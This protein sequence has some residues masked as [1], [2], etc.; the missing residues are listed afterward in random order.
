MRESIQA[1]ISS[2]DAAL[3][4]RLS[5]PEWISA[6]ADQKAESLIESFPG[7]WGKADKR[8]L[9]NLLADGRCY[10][11]ACFIVSRL[12]GVRARDLQ[13]RQK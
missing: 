10:D 1:E 13:S 7:K 5:T 6:H 9:A 2:W 8:K 4:R 12:M 3:D 11:V